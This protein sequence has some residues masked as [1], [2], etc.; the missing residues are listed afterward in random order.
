MTE[1]GD[2]SLS[3]VDIFLRTVGITEDIV[4]QR[5]MKQK[6]DDKRSKEFKKTQPCNRFLQVSAG[7]VRLCP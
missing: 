2:V 4:L 6:E 7:T 3:R 1:S 5:R